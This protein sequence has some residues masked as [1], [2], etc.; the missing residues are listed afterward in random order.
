MVP[1]MTS[2]L[3]EHVSGV[4]PLGGALDGTKRPKPRR[5]PKA[6]KPSL[7]VG[8]KLACKE[9][10]LRSDSPEIDND[11]HKMNLHLNKEAAG[12]RVR[13]EALEMEAAT[14][15]RFVSTEEAAKII[16]LTRE[17]VIRLCREGALPGAFKWEGRWLAARED[18]ESYEKRPVGRPSP[19][20]P[21][22]SKEIEYLRAHQ[23]IPSTVVGEHLGRSPKWVRDR[24]AVLRKL[25]GEKVWP[26]KPPGR[27]R[28]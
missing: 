10:G 25:E 5:T 22:T 19:G 8:L 16:G 15:D 18:I 27:P 21:A 20:G 24:W 3:H 2:P 23:D 7:A 6:A 4:S 26:K 9:C 13:L 28:S 17:T 14:L 11:P 1:T 12:L